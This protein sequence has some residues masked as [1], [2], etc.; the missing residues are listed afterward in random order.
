MKKTLFL[1]AL[2]VICA[3]T[4]AQFIFLPTD[5]II[6]R[7]DHYY[8][9]PYWYDE[10][11][12]FLEDSVRF[13]GMP[14]TLGSGMPASSYN[15]VLAQ[16]HYAAQP[17]VVRGVAAM[18]SWFQA[19]DS[20]PLF[21]FR[22]EERV[23]ITQGDTIV[24]G[25][26]ESHYPRSMVFLDSARWDTMPPKLLLMPYNALTNPTDT[27]SALACYLYEAFFPSPV[28][29][30]DTFYIL[31]SYRSNAV[32]LSSENDYGYA[33]HNLSTSYFIVRAEPHDCKECPE[34]SRL[35]A[36][37]NMQGISSAW[38]P[39]TWIHYNDMS[40][41]V[42][43]FLPIVQSYDLSAL[44]SPSANGRVEGAGLWPEGWTVTVNAFANPGFVFSH[45]DDGVT[46]NPRHV[47]MT[48]PIS[49]TA[50]F[51]PEE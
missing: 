44:A 49:L 23:F 9:H 1:L 3:S 19:M 33:F 34:V 12:L 41:T 25:L 6:G 8:Y 20:P 10:C 31:G 36:C 43:P 40:S 46:D 27:S 30:Y 11:N 32:T 7:S 21:P 15:G 16:E 13:L 39:H 18:V 35:F 37:T 50:F 48:G 42:G 26:P 14:V 45:W 38:T 29:V 22:A 28:M 24:S 47:T 51:M 17:L 4:S 5:T 2:S